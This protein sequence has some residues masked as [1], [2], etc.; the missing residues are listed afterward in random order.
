[1]NYK[2]IDYTIKTDGSILIDYAFIKYQNED[3]ACIQINTKTKY[4]NI[5]WYSYGGGEIA[6]KSDD[7]IFNYT[8]IILKD[9]TTD[10]EVFS[11]LA[12]RYEVYVTLLRDEHA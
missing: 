4:P 3:V 7:D 11:I 1:M 9:F 5:A 6:L 8:T 2:I 10:W 12:E